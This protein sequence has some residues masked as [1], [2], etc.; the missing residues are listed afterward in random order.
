[1]TFSWTHND[2]AITSSSTVN[3][4]ST[5][6]ITNVMYRDSGSYVCTV[7][8]E[9]VKVMSNVAVITVHGK[10]RC[11]SFMLKLLLLCVSSY[12]SGHYSSN[13][14]GSYCI[15]KRDIYVP[16]ISQY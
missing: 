15:Q 1:M 16:S 6:T 10:L 9:S 12:T 7:S 2:T 11:I 14:H 8:S 3:D 4:T 5:L 13:E